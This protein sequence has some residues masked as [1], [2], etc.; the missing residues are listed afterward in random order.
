MFLLAN[1]QLIS[2]IT[3]STDASVILI[4]VFKWF[5][6]IVYSPLFFFF[7]CLTSLFHYI[8][9]AFLIIEQVLKMIFLRWEFSLYAKI[10]IRIDLLQMCVKSSLWK[11]SSKLCSCGGL[12][13]VSK[14]YNFDALDFL[15]QPVC[16][17][18]MHSAFCFLYK[19]YIH[20]VYI[21]HTI[22]N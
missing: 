17:I 8:Q 9:Q 12:H 19:L 14:T 4:T 20:S 5:C 13:I 2:F 6:L 16:S 22:C 15:K 7:F 1:Q 3:P 11:L 21:L 18:C 10:I